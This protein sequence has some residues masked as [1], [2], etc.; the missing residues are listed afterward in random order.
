MHPR[1]LI[2]TVL[3]RQR[4]PGFAGLRQDT[5]RPKPLSDMFDHVR[6]C[7][8]DQRTR[9][10]PQDALVSLPHSVSDGN[11]GNYDKLTYPHGCEFVIWELALR[12]GV[13]M[14]VC[15]HNPDQYMASLRSII[16]GGRK[17]IGLLVGAGAPAGMARDDGTYPLIPAVEGLT[18][19]V[20]DVL[21]PKYG[22][23]VAALLDE[24]KP[25]KDI[26]TLL[27]LARESTVKGHRQDQ[28][29]W[30]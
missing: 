3:Y 14:S 11:Y 29:A 12:E 19:K 20:L 9:V 17:R 15:A 27:S 1:T 4:S 24:L 8:P 26:E 22:A 5:R 16:A 10:R 28:G 2:I 21:G 30:P 23:Q 25:K 6:A 18:K 13:G 7:C